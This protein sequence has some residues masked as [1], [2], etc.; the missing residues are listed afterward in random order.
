MQ[1][2]KF[3]SVLTETF[4]SFDIIMGNFMLNIDYGYNW[5]LNDFESIFG[6]G[7]SDV[8]ITN[9]HAFSIGAGFTW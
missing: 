3:L 1:T 7:D 2:Q 9:F 4:V 8:Q 5:K 6:S